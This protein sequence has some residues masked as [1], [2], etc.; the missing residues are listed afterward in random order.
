M[1]R[2]HFVAAVL[3]AV[4]GASSRAVANIPPILPDVELPAVFLGGRP[5]L[6]LTAADGTRA[7]VWLDTDGSGFVTETL[8]RRL[9]L[10]VTGKRAAV[11]IWR[12]QVPPPGGDGLLPILPANE[13][14]P[15][16]V[17]IDVQFGGT[18]FAQRVWTIDY[19]NQQ[20]VWHS[21]GIAAASDAV[22]PVRLKFSDDRKLYPL[23]PVIVDG[24]LIPMAL[25]T[26]A[27]VLRKP[28][29]VTATSFVTHDR[30]ARWHA[31]HPEWNTKQIAAGVDAIDV[32]DVR[33]AN[34]EI[35]GVM[36]TTR[37][38]D[39]VFEGE[40]VAGKLGSN[41]LVARE[42]ILDYTRSVAAFD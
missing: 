3:G 19:R 23:V 28:G 37:P 25:D 13:N 17:G 7:L 30:F 26:A 27:S 12:E 32:P 33:I 39:D 22:N 38:N 35:G 42:L 18:W 31:K 24:E 1:R 9:N 2:G 40:D 10:S 20:I 4:A 6:R 34:V 8:V 41:A 15:L 36:F 11:P 5:F 21:T 29:D 14:D 16:L